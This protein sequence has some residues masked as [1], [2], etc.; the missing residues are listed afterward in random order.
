MR[1]A[2]R[3]LTVAIAALI[4]ATIGTP[5]FVSAAP[6]DSGND[7]SALVNSR[8]T[9][10]EQELFERLNSI[11]A[12]NGLSALTRDPLLDQVA[13]EW[14]EVMA[15]KGSLSH[16]TDL[17]AQVEQRVTTEWMR[18]G[19]NVGWGPSAEWLHQAFYD[20]PPHRANMLGAYNRVGIGALVESDGD[21]WVTVNF[22]DGPALPTISEPEP[23][24]IEEQP[25]ATWAV[26][27]TGVVT[28]VGEAP[29][30]GDPSGL[31]LAQPIVGIA[32]TPSG[33]GYWLVA[34][35]GGIFAFG[36]AQFHG[37]T[38]GL[39][40]SGPIT[41][42]AASETGAGYWLTGADGG[43][44]TFGDARFSGSA[45]GLGAPV[46]G[47]APADAEDLDY[48][49]YLADGRAIGFRDG[50][51]VSTPVLD[52]SSSLAGVAIRPAA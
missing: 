35:D 52:P 7:V 49:L 19:E 8:D 36:D 31:P 43:L 11:R 28:P 2:I 17:R 46:L 9:E 29:F 26:N 41:A 39:R 34:S 15:P 1:R 6:P 38:G 32:A 10:A 21:V 14:T 45:A 44:F 42:M 48:W 13:I 47:I 3:F 37:S 30:L 20:S 4:V 40:L 18:I 23:T 22:L 33:N 16:R 51:A 5:A 50:P 12:Q 25:A 27:P 24:P